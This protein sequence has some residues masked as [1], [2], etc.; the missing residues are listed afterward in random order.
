[1]PHLLVIGV[2]C[3]VTSLRCNFSGSK[4]IVFD[5]ICDDY[6]QLESDLMTRLFMESDFGTHEYYK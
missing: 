5:C 6:V 4:T 3:V 2:V 1:V